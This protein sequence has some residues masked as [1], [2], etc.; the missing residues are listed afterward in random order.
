MNFA[1]SLL[2]CIYAIPKEGAGKWSFGWSCLHPE[3]LPGLREFNALFHTP[4]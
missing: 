1:I 4:E 2:C 3:S